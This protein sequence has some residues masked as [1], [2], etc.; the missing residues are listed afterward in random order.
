MQTCFGR[1]FLELPPAKSSVRNFAVTRTVKTVT[2]VCLRPSRV[3]VM[4]E[5]KYMPAE[6]LVKLKEN[7]SKG[8]AIIDVRSE[9]REEEGH[10]SGSFHYPSTCF[11]ESLPSLVKEIQGKEAVVVHCAFSQVRG[12]TC[13]KILAQHLAKQASADNP[14]V[15][16]LYKGFNNWQATGLP[17]CNCSGSP[18]K[19]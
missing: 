12:P 15:F 1:F 11:E 3:S 5:L 14:E 4:A 13:A 7:G 16:V 2:R 6:N 10:I 8:V 9:E 18:C 17:I 19:C